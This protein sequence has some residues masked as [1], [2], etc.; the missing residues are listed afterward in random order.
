MPDFPGIPPRALRFLRSLARHNTRDWF[1]AHREEY[2][3]ALLQPLRE[4]VDE[5][6]ARLALVAPEFVGDRRRSVFRIHRDVRF[7]RDKRPYKTNAACWL[8]HRDAGRTKGLHDSVA[9]A[10]FYFHLEPGRCFLGGGC[11]MPPPPA[12]RRLREAIV[13]DPDGLAATVATPEF[14]RLFGALDED[15]GTVL[16]RLP[17]GYTPDTPGAEWLRYKSFTATHDLSDV[18]ASSPAL[19][20]TFEAACRALLPMMRWLNAALGYRPATQ[21]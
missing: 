19:P 7:S 11:W 16:T 10:G 17:R 5:M 13:D 21:R 15:A 1:E 2:E 9:A 12:L 3:T 4:L 18:E 8:F 14:V 20:D 6:D